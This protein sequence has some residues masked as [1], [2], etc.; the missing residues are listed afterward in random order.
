LLSIKSL[1]SSAFAAFYQIY[2]PFLF[3]CFL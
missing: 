2:Y 1:F 3:R